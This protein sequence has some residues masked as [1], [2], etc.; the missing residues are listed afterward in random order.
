MVV[1]VFLPF[2]PLT[3]FLLLVGFTNPFIMVVIVFLPLPPFYPLFIA[4]VEH[5]KN[6]LHPILPPYQLFNLQKNN[7]NRL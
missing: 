5:M 4:C 6:Y 3:H 2:L 1:I 7:N